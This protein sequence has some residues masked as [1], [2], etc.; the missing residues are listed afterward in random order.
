MR[1]SIK[2]KMIPAVSLCI[3]CTMGLLIFYAG[4]TVRKQAITQAE[5]H[6]VTLARNIAWQ[7]QLNL[8]NKFSLVRM[9]AQNFSRMSD[10]QSSLEVD[11]YFLTIVLKNI[12]QHNPNVTAIYSLWEPQSFDQLDIAY[13]NMPGQDKTGRFIPY[14][15]RDTDGTIN[16][17][18]LENYH[19]TTEEDF[20]LSQKAGSQLLF[21]PGNKQGNQSQT[22]HFSILAPMYRNNNYIGA[23]GIE[24]PLTRIEEI[25]KK[26][27]SRDTGYDVYLLNETGDILA[28]PFE[29]ENH[30]PHL[31]IFKKNRQED[32]Q[33]LQTGNGLTRYNKDL[34]E[35]YVPLRL[36]NVQQQ[37]SLLLRIPTKTFMVKAEEV[38]RNMFFLG[39]S[40]CLLSIIIIIFLA[41]RISKPIKK[42]TDAANRA[43]DGKMDSEINIVGNDEV[44]ELTHSF[45]KLLAAGKKTEQ[46]LQ[47]YNINLENQVKERTKDLHLAMETAEKANPAKSEF[48]A[49][50]GL[51]D[52][53]D[54][55]DPL[56]LE[57]KQAENTET[58]VFNAAIL[59]VE[60]NVTNQII[61]QGMLEHLGCSVDLA[62]NGHDALIAVVKRQYDIIFMDCQMPEMD[63]YEATRKIKEL[64]DQ[65]QIQP[66]PIVALTAHAMAGDREQCIAAGMDDYLSKPFN[67]RQLIEILNTWIDVPAGKVSSSVL[68]RRED[69]IR[70]AD[71]NDAHFDFSMLDDLTRLKRFRNG[72]LLSQIIT[73]YFDNCPELISAIRQAIKDENHEDLQKNA[74]TLKSSNAQ[75]GAVHLTYLCDQLEKMGKEKDP[76]DAGEILNEVEQEYRLVVDILQ[77]KMSSQPQP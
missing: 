14:L 24:I 57:T 68:K 47:N 38:T 8:Q 16:L 27:I 33:K 5:E 66:V 2:Y 36:P 70:F 56:Q 29:P 9:M 40:M 18:P 72:N 31:S 67:E 45:N 4:K 43:A 11:R 41:N 73:I 30:A 35:I 12:L 48:L 63:G 77:K 60:D 51:V 69:K 54:N 62:Q 25:I 15:K 3:L 32:L 22:D 75:I 28:A 71:E 65:S 23:V 59:V 58:A 10:P 42:L 39:V 7:L 21:V 26:Q 20:R 34:V 64:I 6:T 55:E 74:H 44:G 52:Q 49:N 50:I 1:I 76:T 53:H 17:F 37:H 46:E 61:T 19:L 13:A